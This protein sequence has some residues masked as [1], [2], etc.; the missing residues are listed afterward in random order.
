MEDVISKN[1][2]NKISAFFKFKKFNI[3]RSPNS[4]FTS[5]NNLRRTGALLENKKG[6]LR[7]TKI[8]E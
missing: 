7:W 3:I 4:A 8:T 1:Q 2:K 5:N 6:G